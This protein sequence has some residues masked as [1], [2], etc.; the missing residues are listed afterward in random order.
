MNAVEM[1]HSLQ[2]K[3]IAFGY[4]AERID[5]YLA[6]KLLNEA[7]FMFIERYVPLL[8]ENEIARK[9]L[10]PLINNAELTPAVH[11]S[12]NNISTYGVTITLP[13]DFHKT[14]NEYITTSTDTVDV[15]PI[16]YDEYNSNRLNP[17]RK[18]YSNLVWRLDLNI[19]G[20]EHELIPDSTITI[21]KYRIRYIRKP[22]T[23]DISTNNTCDLRVEDHE[24]VVNLAI[25]I[26]VGG[27]S[28]DTK[29]KNE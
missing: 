11:S 27:K 12:T 10:H 26:I 22:L 17:W 20:R 18:P 23:I 7:L 9:K 5:S 29:S 6:Q 1:H 24:E 15:K 16:D 19:A 25:S 21:V 4:K 2:E 13:S 3:L 28:N 14:L 8:K